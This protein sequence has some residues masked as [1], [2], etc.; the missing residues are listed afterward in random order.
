MAWNGKQLTTAREE[1][2][3]DHKRFA[4]LVSQD[5]GRLVQV[6]TVKRWEAGNEPRAEFFSAICKVTGKD[7]EYFFKH[8]SELKLTHRKRKAA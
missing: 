7:S 5:I 6:Q 1:I 8:D 2:R 3:A 4:F